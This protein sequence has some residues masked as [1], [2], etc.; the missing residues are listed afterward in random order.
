MRNGPGSQRT[1]R[2]ALRRFVTG[3]AWTLLAALWTLGV[4]A[5]T[6][7]VAAAAWAMPSGH[8]IRRY[9]TKAERPY[10]AG[11]YESTRL[12]YRRLV[13]SDPRRPEYLYNFTVTSSALG[14]SNRV[15]RLFRELA[16]EDRSG[17]GPAHLWLARQ[18]LGR[19]DRSPADTQAAERHLRFALAGQ[20]DS[21]EANAMIGQ[22]YVASGR[23][24]EAVA[25]L[26]KAAGGRPDLLVLLAHVNRCRIPTSSGISRTTSRPR[27][28]YPARTVARRPRGRSTKGSV[29]MR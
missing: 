21:V 17:F 5:G 24:K 1:R 28:G 27:T 25:P 16:P 14:Q 12:C 9:A 7:A 19:T 20:P 22:L 3:N 26:G 29:P 8:L 6:A 18:R 23:P 15:E 2:Q 10:R 13:L 11:D 4:A